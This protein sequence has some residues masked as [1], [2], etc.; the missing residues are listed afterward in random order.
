M[1]FSRM[2]LRGPCLD[3]QHGTTTTISRDCFE[4][5]LQLRVILSLLFMGQ[6]MKIVY[7]LGCDHEMFVIPLLWWLIIYIHEQILF[8]NNYLKTLSM[9]SILVIIQSVIITEYGWVIVLP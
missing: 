9:F 6:E 1:R 3:E 8:L 4:I 2:Q 5:T 7:I